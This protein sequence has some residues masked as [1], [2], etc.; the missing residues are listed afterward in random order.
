M[1]QLVYFRTEK[2][3]MEIKR[4]EYPMSVCKVTDYSGVNLED[5]FVFLG[6]TDEER[7]LVCRTACVPDNTTARDDGWRMMRVQGVLDFSLVGILAKL[8]SVLAERRI[9]IFA[10]STYNTDY[11]LVKAENYERAL[12]A[13]A[14]AGYQIV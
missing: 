7:S 13:L 12:A 8:S 3:K 6:G 11:I 1:L 5:A 9:G 2:G 4:F 14:G 10:V